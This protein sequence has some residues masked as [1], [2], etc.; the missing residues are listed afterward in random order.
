[1][2]K[3]SLSSY[4][5]E[6]VHVTKETPDAGCTFLVL[7]FGSTHFESLHDRIYS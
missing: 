5:R 2:R 7:I 6:E 4:L 3:N 1:M